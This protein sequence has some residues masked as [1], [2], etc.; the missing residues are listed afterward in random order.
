MNR[1][2]YVAVVVRVLLRLIVDF[3]VGK[4]LR[5]SCHLAAK[6][7]T[8]F[9]MQDMSSLLWVDNSQLELALFSLYSWFA[10]YQIVMISF[11][12]SN[13][14]RSICCWPCWLLF[15]VL[16]FLNLS[17]ENMVGFAVVFLALVFLGYKEVLLPLCCSCSCNLL[18]DQLLSELL[19]YLRI[20]RHLAA[21]TGTNS[22][23]LFY[24]SSL[25][26]MDAS[27]LGVVSF[28]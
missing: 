6:F 28:S 12:N 19:M 20:A 10:N 27:Y 4:Y 23:V 26:Q 15:R 14:C 16:V 18:L 9:A 8:N 7:G 22:A 24:K 1:V 5:N 2:L 21:K 3:G 17:L 25:L 13:M 11:I